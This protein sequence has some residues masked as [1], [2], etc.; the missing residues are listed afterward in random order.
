MLRFIADVGERLPEITM[1]SAVAL[2]R[3]DLVRHAE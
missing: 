3:D 2:S 1:L